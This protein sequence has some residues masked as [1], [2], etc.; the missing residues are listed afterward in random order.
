MFH[1]FVKMIHE[2]FFLFVE[3][4]VIHCLSVTSYICNIET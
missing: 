4:F 2:T 1:V 3:T